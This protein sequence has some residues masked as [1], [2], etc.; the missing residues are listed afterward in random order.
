MLVFTGISRT[1]AEIARTR[2]RQPE[3]PRERARMRCS[4]WSITRSK[5][6]RSPADLVEFGRLLDEGWTLKRSSVGSRVE[7]DRG[8][9][10]TKPRCARA[11]SAASCSAPAAA[12]SCC[13]SSGRTTAEVRAA[14]PKLITVPFRFEMSGG[15]IVLYQ[16]DGL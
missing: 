5:S 11:R 7:S 10:C 6:C 1:A 9:I 16:P 3:E 8:S 2:D 13:C 15:R 12:D 4:R 14:L